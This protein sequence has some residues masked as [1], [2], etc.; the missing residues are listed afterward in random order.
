MT[1]TDKSIDAANET[2]APVAVE[3]WCETCGS[4]VKRPLGEVRRSSAGLVFD[5]LMPNGV[6]FPPGL[7][8]FQRE[9]FR[10]RGA[11]RLPVDVAIG[12]NVMLLEDPEEMAQ[13]VP[14][15]ECHG[16]RLVLDPVELIDAARGAH[17]RKPAKMKVRH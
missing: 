9:Q 14:A 5:A 7:R 3:V 15:V 2:G 10:K 11:R 12:R 6:T 13:E 8:E 1:V 17:L 16:Q 4:R